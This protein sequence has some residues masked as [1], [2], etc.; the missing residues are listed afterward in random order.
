[1]GTRRCPPL[2]GFGRHPL[3][4]ASGGE[5]QAV[6]VAHKRQLVA[7]ALFC[8]SVTTMKCEVWECLD[9]FR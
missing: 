1:V 3:G 6:T 9:R 4:L 5:L 7:A 8:A 2:I